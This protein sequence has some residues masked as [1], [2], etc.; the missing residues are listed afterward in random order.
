VTWCVRCKVKWHEGMSC[1]DHKLKDKFKEEEKGM[2]KLVK[3]G[4]LFKCKCGKYIEK[5]DG[6]KYM[7]CS[8]GKYFCW[9]CK[10]VL[11]TDHQDHKCTVRGLYIERERN[12]FFGPPQEEILHD[13]AN[14]FE[15]AWLVGPRPVPAQIQAVRAVRP[16]QVLRPARPIQPARAVRARQDGHVARQRLGRQRLAGQRLADLQARVEAR[17]I[18][19]PRHFVI[20]QPRGDIFPGRLGMMVEEQPQR[21]IEANR[22]AEAHRQRQLGIHH[23]N[24]ALR[25]LQEEAIIGLRAMG[26]ARNAREVLPIQ[27]REA[28]RNHQEGDIGLRWRPAHLVRRTAAHLRGDHGPRFR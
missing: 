26:R 13:I 2:A 19:D 11:K 14:V 8:C 12:Q 6:C 25:R 23:P 4:K 16:I 1:L 10:K 17:V 3:E 18:R 22:R 21:Q 15:H 7:R 24:P 9:A 28:Q 27:Q 20:P 5:A